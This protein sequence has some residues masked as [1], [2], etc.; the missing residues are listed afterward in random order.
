TGGAIKGHI[1]D[2]YM[3]S[4]DECI[5]WGRQDTNLYILE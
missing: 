3:N 2:L 1:I 5:S 4:Y